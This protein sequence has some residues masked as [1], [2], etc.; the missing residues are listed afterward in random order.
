MGEKMH[1]FTV[2]AVTLSLIISGSAFGGV[3]RVYFTPGDKC[4]SEII[5][6]IKTA[7]N[8]DIAVYSITNRNIK[9]ALIDAHKRGANIRIVTD[10]LQSKGKHSVTDELSDAGLPLVT[11]Y[12]YRM[13]YKKGGKQERANDKILH[14]I[15]HN[16]FAVFDD[17][18]VV[19]GSYNWTYS[20]TKENAEN[21]IF[22]DDMAPVYSG[23]FKYLWDLYNT[24]D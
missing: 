15:M 6:N 16:K 22:L 7:N 24:A 12:N 23:Q 3:P 13:T 2:V 18:L 21:C 8:I 10:Y 4:E 1:K 19:T 5:K 9:N 17:K 14:R 20:A 11:N